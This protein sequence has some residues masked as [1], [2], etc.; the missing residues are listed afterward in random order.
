M[1]RRNVFAW[2]QSQPSLGLCLTSD[3]GHFHNSGRFA[4][5]SSL[6]AFETPCQVATARRG[7]GRGH[8]WWPRGPRGAVVLAH[9]APTEGPSLGLVAGRVAVDR[10]RAGGIAV[11]GA[12][13]VCANGGRDGGV[14]GA[15][16][17]G[18]RAARAAR[19]VAGARRADIVDTEGGAA[20]RRTGAALSDG[21]AQTHRPAAVDFAL[22]AVLDRVTA[23][24]LHGC[25]RRW[26]NDATRRDRHRGRRGRLRGSLSALPALL[27]VLLVAFLGRHLLSLES[28]QE[29][30]RPG[31]ETTEG[32]TA[33]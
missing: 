27:L 19:K 29:R 31:E 21:T 8:P 18:A 30:E 20:V 17:S 33:R 4:D 7:R 5:T 15:G 2:T 13:T 28:T 32:T 9:D 16:S 6:S 3:I 12:W 23:G 1:A 25:R 26:D 10:S 22:A 11:R 24:R 14:A